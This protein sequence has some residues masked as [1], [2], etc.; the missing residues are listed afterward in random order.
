MKNFYFALLLAS[1]FAGNSVSAQTDT[2]RGGE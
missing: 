1:A 2:N